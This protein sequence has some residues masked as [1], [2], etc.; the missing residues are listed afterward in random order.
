MA[1]A[2]EP[3]KTMKHWTG[4]SFWFETS[5]QDIQMTVRKIRLWK[6]GSLYEHY[7]FAVLN[8]VSIPCISNFRK[9]TIYN[10]HHKIASTVSILAV[11]Q[12]SI[13]SHYC[14]LDPR[15]CMWDSVLTLDESPATIWQ[16]LVQSCYSELFN[17]LYSFK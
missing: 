11:W 14:S 15:I 3:V 12:L 4:K 2:S 10:N 8:L 7:L 1:I 16:T 6:F 5:Q 9:L 17:V 13:I